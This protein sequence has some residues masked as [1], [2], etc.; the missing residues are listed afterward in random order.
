MLQDIEHYVSVYRHIEKLRKCCRGVLFIPFLSF[1]IV[2]WKNLPISVVHDETQQY[3]YSERILISEI[4]LVIGFWV[5]ET[6]QGPAMLWGPMQSERTSRLERDSRWW[7]IVDAG[8]WAVA[9]E[10]VPCV[11]IRDDGYWLIEILNYPTA[12][13]YEAIGIKQSPSVS[14]T[15]TVQCTYHERFNLFSR[16]LFISR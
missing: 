5:P 10:D 1:I 14:E 15:A 4:S 12:L 11:K 8:S 13:R 6:Q 9:C 3:A 16:N 7:S 2:T